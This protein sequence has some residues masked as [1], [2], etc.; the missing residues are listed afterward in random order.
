MKKINILLALVY[1]IGLVVVAYTLYQLPANLVKTQVVDWEQLRQAQPV[2]T[3]LYLV[4]GI[5]LTIGAAT[6]LGIW[7]AQQD[8]NATS[9]AAVNTHQDRTG[10]ELSEEDQKDTEDDSLQVEGLAEL[11]DSAENEEEIFTKALSLVC[12]HL[13]ASQA[14]AYRTKRTEEYSYIELFASFAY[15]APEGE[16]VTYRFGE[17]LAGQVAKQG[18]CVVID[19]VPE[20][21]LEILSGL[22]KA[23]PTHLILLPIKHNDQ[24]VGVVEI[25]SFIEFSAQQKSS[26]SALFDQLALKLSNNDNVSLEEATS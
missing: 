11:V 1:I 5:S 12:H 3:Q 4:V 24:V 16:E 13:E 10:Y 26:L 9:S 6:L 15:H 21:Y 2:F 8:T 14:A 7:F 19:A 18:E 20:G 22:G 23:S 17:G 25:A